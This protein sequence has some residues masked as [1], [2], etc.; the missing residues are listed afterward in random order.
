MSN[1]ITKDD[2]DFQK[3]ELERERWKYEKE[4]H[5]QENEIEIKKLKQA[6][7][8]TWI[9]GLV[10]GILGT[11]IAVSISASITLYGQKA[12]EEKTIRAAEQ[13]KQE[14]LIQ[15]VNSRESSDSDLRAQIFN[16]L[17]QH[18]FQ[19]KDFRTQIAILEIIGLNFRD[20]LH[21]KPMFERLN[22]EIKEKLE[23]PE[24]MLEALRKASGRIIKDQL[25]QI[26]Q[27]IEG[28]VCELELQFNPID[29]EPKRP[30]CFQDLAISLMDIKDD[31]IM[32]QTNTKN[33]AILEDN[34]HTKGD[35]FVVSFYDMP[36]VDY[37]S[38]ASKGAVWK[39]SIVL[40][41]ID[42]KNQKVKIAVAN[43]PEFSFSTSEEY[44]F[45]EMLKRYLPE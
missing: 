35:D 22:L 33:G 5:K 14:T 6:K 2:I 44:K 15:L 38:V 8:D 43:L 37:T 26:K 32:V 30:E 42:R 17:L 40:K 4:W 19:Q 31:H 21:T 41:E 12:E 9:R 16:T 36:M 23:H 18:Y 27:S 29:R 11:A 39:Y 7:L 20:A 34:E 3:L 10:S 25:Q 1:D 28:D 24:E 45:D 13:R